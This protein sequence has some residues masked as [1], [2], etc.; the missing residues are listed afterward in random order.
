[1][2]RGVGIQDA[3]G[4]GGQASK[5]FLLRELLDLGSPKCRSCND[6]FTVLLLFGR[7][8]PESMMEKIGAQVGRETSSSMAV[9]H[10]NC[11]PLL[12]LSLAGILLGRRTRPSPSPARTHR[13]RRTLSI[14]PPAP[15]PPPPRRLSL[16]EGSLGLRDR[17][18][19]LPTCR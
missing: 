9:K 3:C 1:M 7:R 18:D 10:G 13:G 16:V 11:R 17:V 5:G 2:S 15:P 14:V 12:V 8:V 19:Q 4:R 6:K